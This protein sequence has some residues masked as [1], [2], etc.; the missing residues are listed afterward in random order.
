MYFFFCTDICESSNASNITIDT[1]VLEVSI[2]NRIGAQGNLNPI[3]PTQALFGSGGSYPFLPGVSR[4]TFVIAINA[5]GNATITEVQAN[6]INVEKII[7]Q[8]TETADDSTTVAEQVCIKSLVSVVLYYSCGLD[9]TL[10]VSESDEC[11]VLYAFLGYSDNS[12]DTHLASKRPSFFMSLFPECNG[13][14]G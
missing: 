5:V 6:V 4:A 8:V 14:I 9:V 10:I 13:Y 7:V 12:K 2:I 1:D 11:E 3:S